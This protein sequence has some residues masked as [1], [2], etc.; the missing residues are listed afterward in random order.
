MPRWPLRHGGERSCVIPRSLLRKA[1]M[2]RLWF[3]VWKKPVRW[4]I[5]IALVGAT[6]LATLAVVKGLAALRLPDLK[7]WHQVRLTSE[8]QAR[9]LD[10][11]PTLADYLLLED[12][13][14]AEL[15]EK[16][17]GPLAPE[18]RLA[19]NRYFSESPANPLKFDPARN[20]N[21]TY[22]LFPDGPIR[23]GVLLLH[24]LTDSPYSLRHVA[25]I[26]RRRG[27]Y[28]LGLRLP[29][30]GTVP[31]ALLDAG[32]DDWRAAVKVGARAVRERVG[33][34]MPF[35]VVGYSNG[36]ALALQY[37]LDTVEGSGKR[38]PIASS[39]SPP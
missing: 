37:A 27:F 29:G 19:L 31:A 35:H 12:R 9:D 22:E 25:E 30:H 16:V 21:R 32:W 34:S 33:P 17:V 24:G 18:D 38:R 15:D 11:T 26:Y 1:P 13:L 10:A 4:G 36:G 23:G 5:E 39:S 6:I 7:P 28:A 20:W 2:A 8:F 3:W 14:F